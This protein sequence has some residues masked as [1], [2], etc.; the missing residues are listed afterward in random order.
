[1]LISSACICA[2]VHTSD[3]LLECSPEDLSILGFT[4]KIPFPWKQQILSSKSIELHFYFPK[5][6]VSLFLDPHEYTLQIEKQNAYN[7]L[8]RL[9]TSSSSYRQHAH[10]LILQITQ[11]TDMRSHMD[12]AEISGHLV[13]Y[14]SDAESVFASSIR[15]QMDNW[16]SAI[17]PDAS[18]NQ[19]S[20]NTAL[21]F[22]NPALLNAYLHLP[23]HIFP[24]P[25]SSF[26]HPLMLHIKVLYFGSMI[27]PHLVPD[28]DILLRAF[29]KALS[30][31][32]HPV[33]TLPPVTPGNFDRITDII[34]HLLGNLPSRQEISIND[35]GLLGYIQENFPDAEIELG[36]LLN[37]VPRDV[38]IAYLH[39]PAAC[40][41]LHADF[42][43]HA[44]NEMGIRRASA[45]CHEQTE[46][47]LNLPF[48]LFLP[49]YHMNSALQCT[50][51]NA[52]LFGNRGAESDDTQNCTF[53]CKSYAFLY[54]S[55]L[56]MIGKYNTLWGFDGN[57]L[58]NGSYVQSLMGSSCD[59]IVL[60][61]F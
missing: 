42:W 37:R 33:L 14:P 19:I 23:A 49:F 30:E 51:R 27:C 17:H 11:Y 29:R 8:I 26:S 28:A 36:P 59:R 34:G 22:T 55:F 21:S 31:N 56:H 38:R 13:G 2:M 10:E 20:A 44:L 32:L 4:F 46:T 61:L 48:S 40:S 57:S 6:R 39:R 52:V 54:P 16:L 1:M 7:M 12:M 50:L 53:P 3:G 45:Q 43:I 60:Q 25:Y 41:S 47:P 58:S 5:E 18:W 9:E 35:W 15:E 24:E